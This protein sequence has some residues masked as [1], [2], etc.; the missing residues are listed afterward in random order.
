SMGRSVSWLCTASSYDPRSTGVR[1]SLNCSARCRSADSAVCLSSS[2]NCGMLVLPAL[3]APNSTVSGARRSSPESR[4]ALKFLNR[5]R[6][7]IRLGA[8]RAVRR[9]YPAP[10]PGSGRALLAAL[11][12]YKDQ[13]ERCRAEQA[14]GEKRVAL[15][16]LRLAF[17]AGLQPELVIGASALAPQQDLGRR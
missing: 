16:R 11:R 2:S 15:L 9:S 13:H 12:R 3:L 17:V 10:A 4:Q 1:A 14:P 7:S 8:L 5:S 6:V